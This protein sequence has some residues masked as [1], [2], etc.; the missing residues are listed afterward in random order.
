MHQWAMLLFFKKKKKKEERKCK[1]LSSWFNSYTYKQNEWQLS[2][3]I[4]KVEHWIFLSPATKLFIELCYR[5]QISFFYFLF[6]TVHQSEIPFV[7][8]L[9][10]HGQYKPPER[11]RGPRWDN[12]ARWRVFHIEKASSQTWLLA[13]ITHMQRRNP[14]QVADRRTHTPPR[15]EN[16]MTTIPHSVPSA[17][18]NDSYDKKIWIWVTLAAPLLLRSDL[19]QKSVAETCGACAF[20][21]K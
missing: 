17:S 9:R 5:R 11:K 10:E 3:V 6:V 21:R 18:T 13:W 16:M 7:R 20:L 12:V 2:D 15:E 8:S 1:R 19:F 14:A 4:I